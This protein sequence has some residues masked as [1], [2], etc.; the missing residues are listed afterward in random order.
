M[1]NLTV[2][3]CAQSP[4]GHADNVTGCHTTNPTNVSKSPAKVLKALEKGKHDKYD[5]HAKAKNAVLVPIAFN[6]F[7]LLGAE[8]VDFFVMLAN[9]AVRTGSRSHPVSY[10][11]MSLHEFRSQLACKL[12]YMNYSVVHEWARKVRKASYRL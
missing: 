6:E 12:A 3:T 1:L 4:S 7:G 2:F 5:D 9:E 8:A 10:I 11:H